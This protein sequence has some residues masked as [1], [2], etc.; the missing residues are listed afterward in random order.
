MYIQDLEFQD[1]LAIL[2]A[3]RRGDLANLR[4]DL[5]F[6]GA[7]AVQEYEKDTKQE[8]WRFLGFSSKAELD[9]IIK[10]GS[11]FFA[12]ST[13]KSW[14]T[15][16]RTVSANYKKQVYLLSRHYLKQRIG[17]DMFQERFFTALEKLGIE[18]EDMS[19][20]PCV[21]AI[22]SAVFDIGERD[23]LYTDSVSGLKVMD[24][25]EDAVADG[26]V[27]VAFDGQFKGRLTHRDQLFP[28]AAVTLPL[29]DG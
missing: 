26:Q 22:L 1:F 11:N 2:K 24:P 21:N 13:L 23:K 19:I 7:E 18:H 4:D 29:P 3:T 27:V 12:E 25:G 8:A 6:H 9:G 10:A 5:V 20:V 16:T 28:E 14:V 15:K 17:D